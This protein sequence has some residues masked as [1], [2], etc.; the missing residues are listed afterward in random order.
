[1]CLLG[2]RYQ[3]YVFRTVTVHPQELLC[4]WNVNILL[5]LEF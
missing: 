5:Y 3:L 4:R 1:M 2:L